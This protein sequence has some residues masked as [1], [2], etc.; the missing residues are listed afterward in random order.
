MIK[1]QK[2]DFS[3]VPEG[4][5]EKCLQESEKQA[6]TIRR[7]PEFSG[8]RSD[9]SASAGVGGERKLPPGKTSVMFLQDD[10]VENQRTLHRRE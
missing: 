6:E 4:T 9:E 8:D 2:R 1:T 3:Q 10:K 7:A 5:T